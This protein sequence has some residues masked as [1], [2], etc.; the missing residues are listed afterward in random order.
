MA[1]MAIF[2]HF[3]HDDTLQSSL[4]ITKYVLN[5]CF[6]PLLLC[7]FYPLFQISIYGQYRKSFKLL[8]VILLNVCNLPSSV[9]KFYL[10]PPKKCNA[11]IIFVLL[12]DLET[13]LG[14]YWKN[15]KFS[16][17][18]IYAYVLQRK[19]WDGIIDLHLKIYLE[20]AKICEN[21]N[22]QSFLSIL[23]GLESKLKI[24]TKIFPKSFAYILN[25]EFYCWYYILF[26]KWHCIF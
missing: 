26:C 17:V 9:H 13:T 24:F 8:A 2:N 11:S 19:T 18:L 4:F 3:K 20:N 14:K 25:F 5:F 10:K 7:N 1:K 6:L 22:I 21:S 12:G 15:I 23:G 16:D